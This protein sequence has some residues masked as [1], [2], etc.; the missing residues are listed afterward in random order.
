M[1]HFTKTLFMIKN[2][3]FTVLLLFAFQFAMLGQTF[4]KE[5]GMVS[6]EELGF[7]SFSEMEDA[8]AVVLFDIGKS[9]FVLR[10]GSIE[11][12]FERR[13]RVKILSAA[14][15]KWADIEIPFYRDGTINERIFDIEAYA[16]NEENGEV[17]KTEF[18]NANTF[19]EI[20]DDRW[21]VKKFAI[22]NVKE[23]TVIEYRY[24]VRSQNMFKLHDWEFQWR[25]PALYSEYEVRMIPFYEYTWLLQGAP[26][27]DSYALYDSKSFR[28][29]G[30]TIFNDKVHRFKMKDIPAFDSEEFITSIN[31]YIIKIDFQLSKINHPDG[32]SKSIITTWEDMN[33]DL[34]KHKDFGGY[35]KS[36]KR[37]ASRAININELSSKSEKDKFDHII[38]YVKGNYN[39]NKKNAKYASKTPRK[40]SADKFGNSADINLFTIGL[41]N[42]AG[43]D[44][45]PVL[46]S[47]RGN[48][49]IAF[50]YPY[51]H[52]FNYVVILAKINGEYKFADATEVLSLIDRLPSRALNDKGLIVQ[53]SKVEWLNMTTRVPSEVKTDMQMELVDHTLH[54]KITIEATE[55]DALH[56]R[57]NFADRADR[58]K[59][60]LEA[61]GYEIEESSIEV[62]N[63]LDIEK[64]YILTYHQKSQPE[65]HNE[66][67]YLSPLLDEVASENPLKQK[68][69]TYPIDMTY[70]QERKYHASFQI[71]DGFEVEHLPSEENMNNQLFE[72]NYTVKQV[73]DTIDVYLDYQFKKHSYSPELYAIVQSFFDI[74]V[75]KGNEKIVLVKKKA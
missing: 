42:A 12:V 75:K 6:K 4:D 39:W 23:G 1:F 47:T 24:K 59:E 8:E 27:L 54:S 43:I 37:M 5:F 62:Q 65:I 15:E 26:Q 67:I 32:V 9:N 10:G 55:Y 58:I 53:E 29:F 22:P 41:L 45:K 57:N 35:I 70:P 31:D 18:N 64:P 16:Y 51:T 20:V 11:L 19:D 17:K 44:A 13:T 74:I 68:E 25:I 71:P 73:D 61:S 56:L 38:R 7:D 3:L 48:G 33:K 60:D 40:L 66:K 46:I 52:F 28:R 69:R 14:G 72:L 30:P 21:N 36:S 34:L 49:K 50:D 63:Y 2:F